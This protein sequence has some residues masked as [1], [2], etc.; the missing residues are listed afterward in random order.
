MP[1]KPDSSGVSKREAHHDDETAA[2]ADAMDSNISQARR[3][4]VDRRQKHRSRFEASDLA[5]D[6]RHKI[7]VRQ[8]IAGSR[9]ER[10]LHRPRLQRARGLGAGPRK[11]RRLL[12]QLRHHAAGQERQRNAAHRFQPR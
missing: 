11:Y 5:N 12:R 6:L 8:F 2:H 4:V 1:K 7:N 9:R 3:R 10:R